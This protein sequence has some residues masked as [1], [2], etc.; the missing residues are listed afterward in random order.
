MAEVFKL[1][2]KMQN[3][4]FVQGVS[5]MLTQN[6][7]VSSSHQNEQNAQINMSEIERH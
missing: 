4:K 1:F 7:R 3:I 2:H 6:S 5:K